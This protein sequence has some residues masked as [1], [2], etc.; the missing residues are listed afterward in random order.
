MTPGDR[1]I[2]HYRPSPRMGKKIPATL[3]KINGRFMNR[4]VIRTDDE[5]IHFVALENLVRVSSN[6]VGAR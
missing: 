5:V 6:L 4:A 3:V 2:W 1:V